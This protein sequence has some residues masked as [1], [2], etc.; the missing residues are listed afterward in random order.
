MWHQSGF[1]YIFD[2]SQ[3]RVIA[4][5]YETAILYAPELCCLAVEALNIH[6]P[7]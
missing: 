6:I 4:H 1:A 5:G 2:Q 7:L 3:V